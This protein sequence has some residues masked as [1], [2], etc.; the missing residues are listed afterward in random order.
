[1]AGTVEEKV[2]EAVAPLVESMGLE[3]WGIRYRGG[4]DHGVLQI[5]VDSEDGV[6][7]DAC[8][9]LA[10]LISPALDV[11]DPIGPAYTLEVSSPG[12]DRI[13]FTREQAER[14]VGTQVRA[15]LRIP[16]DGRRRIAGLLRSM[17][18]GMAAIEEEDGT[19]IESAF[20]NIALMRAVPV[21]KS[22]TKKAPAGAGHHPDKEV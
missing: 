16:Q 13:I 20:S 1:M 11:A 9:Q 19:V 10:D 2:R 7:A 12:L 5:F 4:R 17:D 15:E 22:N 18:G 14:Y 6:S 21:F 3:L 8:G